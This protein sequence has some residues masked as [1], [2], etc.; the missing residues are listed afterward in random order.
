M[1]ASPGV[2]LSGVIQ[3]IGG[4]PVA[5]SVQIV[6]SN[7]GGWAPTVVGSFE[8]APIQV[9]ATANGSGVWSVV[10][11]GNYQISP[12]GTFYTVTVFPAGSNA[13]A[14]TGQFAFSAGGSFDL[15]NLTPINSPILPPSQFLQPPVT[16]AANNTWT[17]TNG[18]QAISA[19]TLAIPTITGNVTFSG[20]L[21]NIVGHL[22]GAAFIEV[23]LSASVQWNNDTGISRS[24]AGVLAVGNGSQ[25]DASGTV[26][27]GTI[28]STVS[29][30]PSSSTD[31]GTTGQFAWDGS[32]FYVCT[33]TNTW[34]RVAITHSGW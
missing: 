34:S 16:L 18:F 22:V 7:L 2:T 29:L 8:L 28:I 27:A 25:G 12:A 20:S 5:G 9:T 23:G 21:I 33:A 24:S 14:W 6:L 15:S 13:G 3:D 11:F 4:N 19:T 26:A 1:S 30:T 10:L 31:T 32:Y 17:G